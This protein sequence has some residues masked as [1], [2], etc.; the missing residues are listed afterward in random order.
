VSNIL[1]HR[2]HE[3]L[4]AQRRARRILTASLR[5][6]R[7]GRDEDRSG[8]DP[9][10]AARNLPSADLHR[11]EEEIAMGVVVPATVHLL[12]LA[13]HSPSDACE[14]A[15]RLAAACREVSSDA[16]RPDFWEGIA[17]TV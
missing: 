13:L 8:F 1:A 15:G 2:W 4:Q 14:H 7:E 16:P 3:V 5:E 11:I 6:H 12:R 10:A 9:E 17:A